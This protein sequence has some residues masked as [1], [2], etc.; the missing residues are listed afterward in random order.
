MTLFLRAALLL[1]A[2]LYLAIGTGF[3]IAPEQLGETFGVAAAGAKGLASM[4]ADFTGFF[5]LLGGALGWGALR[6]S[7]GALLVGAFLAATALAGRG[8][9]LLLDG[10]YDGALQPMVV[11]ALTVLLALAGMRAFG[12][13]A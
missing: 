12:R 10:N 1:L 2:L 7:G 9:S 3:L 6:Q 5:W 13:K 4:R 8:L 11:E